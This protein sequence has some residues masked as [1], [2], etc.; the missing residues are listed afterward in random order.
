MAQSVRTKLLQY[1]KCVF[2]IQIFVLAVSFLKY[3]ATDAYNV[4]PSSLKAWLVVWCAIRTTQ[5]YTVWTTNVSRT[6]LRWA[7]KVSSPS[8]VKLDVRITS[9]VEQRE[10]YFFRVSSFLHPKITRENEDK[11]RSDEQVIEE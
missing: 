10:I 6:A 3:P 11:R 9:V 2:F 5:K 4:F 8:S 1:A 7:T